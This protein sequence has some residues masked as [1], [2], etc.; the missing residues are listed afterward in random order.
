[1]S[2]VDLPPR[3]LDNLLAFLPQHL[4]LQLAL[5]NFHFY[6]PC[7]RHLYKHIVVQTNPVLQS[8]LETSASADIWTT[9]QRSDYI[10]LSVTTV[11]GFRLLAVTRAAHHKLVA[12]KLET[13]LHA[14]LVNPKLA[15]CINSVTVTGTFDARTE[16]VLAKLFGALRQLPNAVSKVYISDVALRSTLHYKDWRF[17]LHSVTID[18]IDQLDARYLS[19]FPHLQ[20]LI[21]ANLDATADLAPETIAI[22]QKLRHLRCKDDPLVYD[23]LTRALNKAYRQTPFV[24]HSLKTFSAV[25]THDNH[26]TPL[27]YVDFARLEN[28]QVSLGCDNVDSCD[29]ECLG[30][31]LATLEFRALKRL[32]VVH[33]SDTDTISHKVLEKWDI[34]VFDFVKSV[35]E[36]APGLFYLSI[37]HSVPLDGVI[38]DGYEGNYIRKVKLYTI[39]LPRLLS[40][41]QNHIVNLVLP[42]F[43]ATLACYEQPMNTFLWNGCKCSHC[44]AILTKLDEFLLYHRYFKLSAGVFK[45]LQTTQLM[46]TMAEVL[47]DRMAYDRNLGD[48]HV[49]SQPLQNTSWNFHDNKFSIPFQCLPVKTYDIEEMEDDSEQVAER[50]ERFFDAESKPN[51]CRF[52][53]KEQ[54][55]PNYSI[56]VSHYLDDLI[57]KMINLNRGDAEDVDIGRVSY[58]ND[59]WTN[60]QINKM[61]VNGIDYNFD[62]EINGTIFY[63]NSFDSVPE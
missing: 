41:L 20:E 25:L 13:L 62:H 39:I 23:R 53:G 57:R 18:D 36:T 51:D 21:V 16:A 47:S 7:A 12:A 8:T 60:L 46:R 45:D 38:S 14:V 22:L 26:E 4:L 43:V 30:E 9:R 55:F 27:P 59:G 35:L 24:L 19:Q 33:S 40:A 28:F 49:L 52:L 48:L 31:W 42:N 29:H 50:K 5:T 37:R 3:V 58:E 56:V 2:L 44:D 15:T 34:V 11:C 1:M 10:H 17:D 61:L 32:S 54:F 63:S 6:E